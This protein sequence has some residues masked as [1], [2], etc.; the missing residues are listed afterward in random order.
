MK[1]KSIKGDWY[2]V[3]IAELEAFKASTEVA[4]RMLDLVLKEAKANDLQVVKC[5]G[6]KNAQ[7]SVD[8]YNRSLSAITT[9]LMHTVAG[10]QKQ[11]GKLVGVDLA[12]EP[13]PADEKAAGNRPSKKSAP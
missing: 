7:K 3:P 12:A 9:G 13:K 8:A 2:D 11:I 1:E 5:Q 10:R 4:L 6:W